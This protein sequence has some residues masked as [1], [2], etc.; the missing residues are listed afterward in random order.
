MI[1]VIG[2]AHFKDNLSYSE[3][4]SDG[5]VAEKKAVLDFIVESF[6]DCQHIVFMGD[7][8]NAKNNSS[9]TNREFVEFI[10]RFG[11]KQLH[12][13][14]GNHEKKGDGKTAIDFIR[15]ITRVN[16][17]VYTEPARISTLH[18]GQNVG[19]STQTKP[20]STFTFLPYMLN[21]E[22]GVETPAEATEKIMGEMKGGDII[23]AHHMISGTVYNGLK[24][25]NALEVVLPKEELENRYKL[26]VAGHIHGAQQVGRT[27]ITGNLFT[28]QVGDVEKYIYKINDKLEVERLVVPCRQIHGLENP[29]VSKLESIPKSSILKV[30]ITDKDIDIDA[31]RYHLKEFD[32]Y[33][34]IQD[35]P[36]ERKKVQVE[37]GAFDFSIEALLRLYAKEKDISEQKLFKGLQLIN[38]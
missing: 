33:L 15:E 4:I 38:S 23:F 9:E 19:F 20:I 11:D 31:L 14:S 24:T 30:T 12:I 25:D 21:S 35:Y 36:N 29:T 27:W 16:W 28:T 13:L 34:L 18:K 10:E 37:D 6:K 3:Y 1:G 2:D 7:N 26:V 17:H 5:R 32:A 22:L 8:F